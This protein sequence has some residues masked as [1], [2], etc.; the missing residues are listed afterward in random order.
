HRRLSIIDL[1]EAG[2]QPLNYKSLWIT[3]NGEIY[4]YGEIK[5]ELLILKHSFSGNSDTEVILH[6]YEEWGKEC[7]HK[8]IG[9][10][11]FVI[12]DDKNNHFFCARDRAG[13]KPFYYYFHDG[14]FLFAS[15]LKAFHQ[16]PLFKKEINLNSVAEFMQYGN[17]PAPNCIFNYCCK[18][19]PGHYLYFNPDMDEPLITTYWNVYNHYNKPK[20][21]ISFDEAKKETEKL[22]ASAANYRM[23]SDVPVGV[24]LSGGYDS[25]CLTALLQKDRPYKLK[26]FTIGVT[27]KSLNEAPEAKKIAE[28][29]GTDHYEHYC[30]EKEALEIIP[31]LPYYYDEPFADHSAIPTILVSKIAR[32]K[33]KVA[34]SADGGDEVFAGY[35]RYSYL[36]QLKKIGS[37]PA[38]LRISSA[39]VLSRINPEKIPFSNNIFNFQIRYNKFISLLK[40]PSPENLISKLSKQ[41]TEK[42]LYNL[43]VDEVKETHGAFF[44]K[45]LAPE[46]YTPL[47]YMMAIDYQT[48]LTDDILHKVDRASMSQGLEAREPFLDH[49]LIE[50]VATLPDNY[51]YNNHTKKYILKEIVHKYIPKTLMNRPKMGFSIPLEK[52]LEKELKEKIYSYVNQEFLLKQGIFNPEYIEFIVNSFYSGKKENALRIWHFLSFQMWF[53]KWAK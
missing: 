38:F 28:Y 16:H 45:E 46:F 23:V 10:F 42:E 1:S 21:D 26:T 33:V 51:K 15:E 49:R 52:W 27:D 5:N 43:F 29:L 25:S 9:M 18:L 20:L 40:D 12:Y 6:A 4:N 37:I 19:T 14:L 39:N 11:A 8:F 41:F 17:V 36:K 32:I 35:N 50:W 2:R 34:L 30:T 47:S 13:V 53:E 24:F 3:F 44:S 31:D 48:Y 22:L 7:I